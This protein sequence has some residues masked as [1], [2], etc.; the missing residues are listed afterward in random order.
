MKAHPDQPWGN[1]F[2]SQHGEDIF[3]WNL[4]Q[5]IG[6]KKPTYLDIGAHHPFNISNTA[7]FYER[8]CRGCN[9]EVN[10]LLIEEFKEHRK[11]DINLNLGITPKAG[12]SLFYKYDDKSG[13]NTFSSEQALAFKLTESMEI[14][15]ITLKML[16]DEY[17][18][19]EFPFL[20]FTDLEGLDCDVILSHRMEGSH[21]T[22][23]CSEVRQHK[24]AEFNL[25]MDKRGFHKICRIDENVIYYH[26]SVSR[27]FA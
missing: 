8:G 12:Q 18:N 5:V 19:G 20:L 11:D 14:T 7:F 9:V 3:I 10:P 1:T 16:V 17:L 15:T 2:Y 6:V 23:I 21:P 25:L 24:E 13:L 26:S 27:Y 22:I 4:C